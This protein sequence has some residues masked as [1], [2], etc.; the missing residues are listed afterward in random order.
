M[1]Q[2][3]DDDDEDD[4]SV[5]AKYE[6]DDILLSLIHVAFELLWGAGAID[7]IPDSLHMFLRLLFG[8]QSLLE[9]NLETLDDGKW[10]WH[11]IQWKC[12]VSEW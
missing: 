11:L 10:W 4:F 12:G 3:I 2:V 5:I 1:S 9:G 7:C 8:G 6:A